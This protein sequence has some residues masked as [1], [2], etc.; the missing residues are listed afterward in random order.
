MKN[1]SNHNIIVLGDSISKG[2]F[3]EGRN[4]KKIDKSA[5]EIINQRYGI[6]IK[7]RSVFGQTLKRAFDKGLITSLVN[8]FEDNKKNIVVIALGGNDADY[9]WKDVAQNPLK[10]HS[11]KTPLVEFAQLLKNCITYL[12]Q[13]GAEVIVNSIFPMDSKRYFDAVISKIADSDSVLKFLDSDITNL[14]RHQEGFNN[15]V[16]S[17]VAETGCK[18]IDYRSPLLMQNDFLTYFCDDGIHPNQKGQE[19]IASVVENFIENR[20]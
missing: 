6:D 16:R 1:L 3:L 7:N 4:I 5:I 20:Q 19:F 9:D 12:Q 11:P 8:D 18:F 14:S 10:E 2:V 17:V 13:N 15:A